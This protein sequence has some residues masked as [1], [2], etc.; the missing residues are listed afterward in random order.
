MKEEYLY[1]FIKESHKFQMM[2]DLMRYYERYL[3]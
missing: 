2:A 1:K 3:S